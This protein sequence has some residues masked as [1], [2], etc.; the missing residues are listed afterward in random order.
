MPTEEEL[1]WFAR[2][3]LSILHREPKGIGQKLIKFSKFL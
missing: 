2:D 3:G 1:R